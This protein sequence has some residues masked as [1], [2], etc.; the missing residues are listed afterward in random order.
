[1]AKKAKTLTPFQR[2]KLA[3]IA[4][5]VADG[6]NP[7]EVQVVVG[8]VGVSFSAKDVALYYAQQGGD[9]RLTAGAR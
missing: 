5:V 1:M 6:F 7:L 2:K 3:M 8:G 4:E 9:F